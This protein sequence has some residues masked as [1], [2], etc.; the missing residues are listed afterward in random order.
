MMK[1]RDQLQAAKSDALFDVP[2][3][4]RTSGYAF[5]DRLRGRGCNAALCF[6]S[7]KEEQASEQKWRTVGTIRAIFC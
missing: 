6:S 4:R 2:D 3:L 5:W 7:D 1:G